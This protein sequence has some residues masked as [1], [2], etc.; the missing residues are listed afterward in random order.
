M[1]DV[2]HDPAPQ[3]IDHP[4][5]RALYDYWDGSREGDRLPGRQHLDPLD[6]PDLLPNIMLVDVKSAEDLRYR[7]VGTAVAGRM[8]RDTTGLRVQD[9]YLGKDWEIILPD[10]FYVIQERRPC[11]RW[12]ALAGPRGKRFG[13]QR[14][15]L[16]L[17]RDGQRVDMLL[18]GLFWLD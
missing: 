10:Y 18:A 16:P 7:L 8:G 11:L 14:L 17:A 15:L 4:G 9:G 6:I 13:Y 3:A 12:H 5:L 1:V 2:V